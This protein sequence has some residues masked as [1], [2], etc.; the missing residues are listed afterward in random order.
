MGDCAA[1]LQQIEDVNKGGEGVASTDSDG[2][3]VASGGRGGGQ[4]WAGDPLYGYYTR[5]KL[6][7]F[8]RR[9]MLG[10]SGEVFP[11]R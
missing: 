10:Q 2:P 1:I 4:A 3:S 8:V 11:L 6:V 5:A 9:A 7:L